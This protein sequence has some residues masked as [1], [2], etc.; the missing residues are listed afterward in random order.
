LVTKTLA[1]HLLP[2]IAVRGLFLYGSGSNYSAAHYAGNDHQKGKKHRDGSA[3]APVSKKEK[4]LFPI[5][6]CV[7]VGIIIPFYP[8][9]G[10]ADAWVTC[11]ANR[12]LWSAVQNPQNELINIVTIFLGVTVGATASAE[13]FLRKET[14]LILCMG[15]AAFSFSTFGRRFAGQAYV[16]FTRGKINL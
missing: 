5:V 13:T 3:D 6:V 12:G 10:N 14:L 7:I 15:L 16:S 2:A 11:S 9:G 1:A 8:P 4:I